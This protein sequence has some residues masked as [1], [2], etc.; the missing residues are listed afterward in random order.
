MA[1]TTTTTQVLLQLQLPQV[2]E[3]H[4]LLQQLLHQ[5]LFD[6][7]AIMHSHFICC[8]CHNDCVI[9]PPP[10]PRVHMHMQL[11]GWVKTFAVQEQRALQP[12]LLCFAVTPK[13]H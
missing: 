12:P 4:L 1:T 8:A 3:T 5:V 9:T 13:Q 7:S 11:S 2:A 10:P 6:E